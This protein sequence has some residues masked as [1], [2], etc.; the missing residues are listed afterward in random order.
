[1]KSY[2]DTSALRT[3]VPNTETPQKHVINSVETNKLADS[4][5]EILIFKH[6]TIPGK[7]HAGMH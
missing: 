6:L 7:R 1:M 2:H 3:E 5:L 4:Q